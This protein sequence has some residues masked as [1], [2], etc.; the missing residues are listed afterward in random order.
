MF[1]FAN[2]WGLAAL[3]LALLPALAAW[4]RSRAGARP[5]FLFADG[6]TLGAVPRTLAAR[7]AP[8]TPLVRCLALGLLAVAFARPQSGAAEEEILS[9]GIDIVLA[10]DVSG[11][12]RAL[13]FSPK[14]R[15]TVARDVVG[16]FIEGRR[17]DR[18]GLVTFAR[19]SATRCPLTLDTAALRAIVDAVDFAPADDDGTAIGMGLATACARLKTARG[20]SRVVVL[21]TDGINNAG[22]VDPTT[23]AEMARGLGIR[24]HTIGVGKKG[25]VPLP[26]ADGRIVRAD[27]PIDDDAMR[28]ISRRTGGEYFR[29]QDP[30]GLRRIFQT[31][32]EMEK[33]RVEVRVFARWGDLFPQLLVAG[34]GLLLLEG[35]A[36]SVK[37]RILP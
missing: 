17:S 5:A 3:V 10:L 4:R 28:D 36:A 7:L 33:S 13:D 22:T 16:R 6:R 15:L 14:D 26:L 31:I 12:M 18:I 34:A 1:R 35:A 23:A 19:S 25:S 27:M 21:L 8:K 30:D 11:S 9:E 2:P 37:L 29:A 24:V 20:K 32:D